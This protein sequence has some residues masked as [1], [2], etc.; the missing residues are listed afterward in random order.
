M[1]APTGEE[2]KRHDEQLRARIVQD[3]PRLGS[4]ELERER[5]RLEQVWKNSRGFIG[6]LAEVDHKAIGRRFLVTSFIW[7][8]LGGILAALMRI[9]LA[10]PENTFLGPDL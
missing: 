6:W 1:R 8:A 2:Q 4:S 9:Q 3:D 5:H 7:F 10:R